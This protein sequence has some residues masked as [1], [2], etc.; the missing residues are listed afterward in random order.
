MAKTHIHKTLSPISPALCGRVGKRGVELQ[1]A[2]Q[3]LHNYDVHN[4]DVMESYCANCVK[5]LRKLKT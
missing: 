3:Q 4:Y 5:K 2:L 1:Y